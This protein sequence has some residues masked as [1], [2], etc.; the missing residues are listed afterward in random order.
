MK[1][2]PI[3]ETDGGAVQSQGEAWRFE[4][5]RQTGTLRALLREQAGHCAL[6][7]ED[8][9]VPPNAV[10]SLTGVVDRDEE[11]QAVRG[12]LCRRCD[13]G[14]RLFGADPAL[15]QRAAAYLGRGRELVLAGG[16]GR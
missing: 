6:C 9:V 15:M 5:L 16:A 13:M 10:D 8:L 14:L 12:L 1:Q 3:S 4:P 11:T 7:A 2:A